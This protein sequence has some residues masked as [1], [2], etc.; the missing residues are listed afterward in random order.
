MNY[1]IPQTES[2]KLL[3]VDKLPKDLQPPVKR[4]LRAAE[5]WEDAVDNITVLLNK[6]IK[7]YENGGCKIAGD[8][9]AI[10]TA[11]NSHLS[12]L[13]RRTAPANETPFRR[14]KGDI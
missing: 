6:K 3:L 11:F 1:S 2:S 4:I 7:E 8:L 10:R 5:S 12:P 13:E 14:R 9:R